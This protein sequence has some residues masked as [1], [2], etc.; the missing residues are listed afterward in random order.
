MPGPLD[1][2]AARIREN[3]AK[4]P[5]GHID[6]PTERVLFDGMGQVAKVA[7]DATWATRDAGGVPCEVITP[8]EHDRTIVYFHGGAFCLGTPFGYRAWVSRLATACR[9]ETWVVDY[10]LAPEHPFPA[11]PDDAMRAWNAVPAATIMMGD[12]AGANLTLATM[13]RARAEG[14]R[15]PRAVVMISPWIDLDHTGASIKTNAE[16]DPLFREGDSRTYAK[17]YCGA[18]SPSDPRV[19]PLFAE[20]HGLPPTYVQVGKEE[21]LLDDSTRFAE[22]ARAAGASVKLDLYDGVLHVWHFFAGIAPEAD[23]AIARI[24]SFV[25]DY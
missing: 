1:R 6:V 12:S 2:I 8:K 14:T 11:A 5:E 17:L 22:K 7:P 13:V 23:E 25:R 16:L 15:L 24:A 9:A 21:C 4:R 10:R 19:S 3:V 18:C 20:L